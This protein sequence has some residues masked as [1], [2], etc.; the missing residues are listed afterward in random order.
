MPTSRDIVHDVVAAV[1]RKL[2]VDWTERHRE[3]VRAV[4]RAPVRRALRKR[5]MSRE[6]LAVMTE[7]VMAQAEALYADWPLAA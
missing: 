5:G 1:K 6:D 3:D 7:R 4:I 2:K